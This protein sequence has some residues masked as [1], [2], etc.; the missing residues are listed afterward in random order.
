MKT[1]FI[2]WIKLG[3]QFKKVGIKSITSSNI[4]YIR[5][6]R[7]ISTKKAIQT[8]FKN[9]LNCIRNI[10]CLIAFNFSI[11]SIAMCPHV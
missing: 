7:N 6:K 3:L 11:P 5:D 10:L 9:K 1:V 4:N 2:V 8:T